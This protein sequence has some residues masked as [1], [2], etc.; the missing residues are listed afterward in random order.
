MLPD[1]EAKFRGDAPNGLNAP[2]GAWCSLTKD[3][4]TLGRVNMWSQ[5]TY[6]CVVLP[7]ARSNP[8]DDQF[9]RMSQC[10]Y[11]CVVLPDKNKEDALKA[12]TRL[13]APT[14]AWCSLTQIMD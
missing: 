12:A 1:F 2:T 4:D 14:G 8:G 11:R 6:R 5:C 9:S 7:D 10:T 3:L 13:N